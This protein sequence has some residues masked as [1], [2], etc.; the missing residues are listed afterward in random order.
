MKARYLGCVA[1]LTG[2]LPISSPL[3][4][5][6]LEE[7]VVTAQRRA[8]SIQEVPVAVS[9]FTE[10]DLGR[11]GVTETLDIAKV[12]PNFVAHNNTGL[13]TANTY[14]LR[15]LNNTESI[16][17]FDPPV[18]TYVDDY[19]IQR[20]NANN[21]A[22]FDIDRV[23]VL[24]GP[25]GTLFGRNTTGGAVRVI[26]A[27]PAD[28]FGG[29]FE[30]GAG[31]FDRVQFRAGVDIPISESF[32]TK[33]SAYW[34]NDDGFVENLTTGQDGLNFEDNYGVRAQSFAQLTE[35]LTWDASVTY[36]N[37]EH[38]NMFNFADEDGD[39]FTRTG[40]LR[41]FAP[42]AGQVVGSK[43][44]LGLGNQTESLHLTSDVEI[45]TDWGTV[46]FLTSYLTLDQDFLLDFFEGPF[47]TGG[48]TIANAGEHDQFTQ[49]IKISGTNANETIDYVA[50]IFYF[51]EENDTD[52]AQIFNLGAI[53]LFLPTG[54]PLFQYD[55]ILENDTDSWAVYGQIDWRMT[56]RTT[57]TLG[58]RYTDEE[59]EIELTDNGNPI[60]A[61]T[62]GAVITSADLIAAGV[63]LDQSE[64]L[65]TPRV[66][67][68]FQQTDDIMWYASVTRGFKSG[69]WNA[70]GTLAETL[71]PFSA[72]KVWN[73]EA[74]L[75]SDWA[76]GRV[77]F[78][79]TA[80]TSDV[81]DFQLPSAFTDPSGGITFI[82][83]NFADLDIN[84]LEVEFMALP[85]DNL[86]L[87]ANLGLLD[88]EYTNLNPSIIAQ[89]ADCQQ[90]GM[91]CAQGIVDPDGDIA[92]PVR[93]PEY[94]ASLG[95]WWT[96]PLGQDY[97]LV[98]KIS[99]VI[100]GDHNVSTAGQDSALVDGYSVVSGGITLENTA[101]NWSLSAQCKNCSDR[102]Q[103]V[104][105]LAGFTY[106]QDPMTWSLTFNKRFG[107]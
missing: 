1:L 30:A 64:S 59:K 88:S 33:F 5:Q 14:S 43:Q 58:A 52:F 54:L 69:G 46:N 12:V 19:F 94:Q 107:N 92:D 62:G 95:G 7:V 23:E 63:P 26:L 56:E 10:E 80:F 28:E 41:G 27:D 71:Q 57:L 6:S 82:T 34:I 76:D 35:N 98:P 21:Y 84:G 24:R 93:S 79:V 66:S 53:G 40:L 67:I 89:Q 74:G 37:A 104:S 20:Q 17:T 49:E 103:L 97:N 44:D 36:I 72:E 45:E 25:Q 96:I 31:R 13:G 81:E 55:R 100:Y 38:A 32:K 78:N 42:L 15:G 83:R 50:G 73:Y 39:R 9:A 47:A 77:R 106:L 29:Y 61:A 86:T 68:S 18:G 85:T 51:S 87:F 70:R 22:L 48:F 60:V 8:E 2:A 4:A 101:A 91:Q 65:I 99:A 102:D 16:A 3:L 75:R 105:F 90:N 11:M